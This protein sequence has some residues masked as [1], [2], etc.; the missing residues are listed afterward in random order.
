MSRSNPHNEKPPQF[1]FML[2]ILAFA[3]TLILL[4]LIY[5]IIDRV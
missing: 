5:W 2:R 3:G 1:W 4:Y